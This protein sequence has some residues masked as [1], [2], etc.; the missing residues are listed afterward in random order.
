MESETAVK[1]VRGWPLTG[2]LVYLTLANAWAVYRYYSIIDDF[3]RHSDPRFT[4]TLEWALPVLMVLAAVNLGAVILLWF[5]RKWGFYIFVVTACAAFA[6]N[7]TLKVPFGTLLLGLVGL[8]I[9]WALLRSHW[10]DFR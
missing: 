3:V 6:I 4:G 1:P 9:L 7:V 8:I 5:W 2:W 10:S